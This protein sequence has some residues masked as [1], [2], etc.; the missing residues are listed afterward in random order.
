MPNQKLENLLN[1]SLEVS[2]QERSR[3]QQLETGY[4]PEEKSWELIVKYSGSLDE[5]RKLGV[6]VEEMRNEYA[7]LIVPENLID[8][9]SALPQIEYVEKPKRLFFA[10]NR[11]K[12][13]SCI[14]IL[15]EP[16]RSLTGRGVLIGVLDSG[17]D[18]FHEDFRNPDGTTRIVALWDQTLNQVFTEMDIN[19]ALESGNRGEA[20]MQVPSVDGSG[21]GTSVAGIAAGNGRESDGAYRG[22]AYESRLLIVKLGTARE[23]GFP[24]TTELMRAVDFVVGRAV[25]M[26]M[27]L[28]VNISFGNTYGSHDGTGLLETFLDDIGNYGRN[29]IV[30]GSGNEGA[31]AGH[32][33][34]IFSSGGREQSGSRAGGASGYRDANIELSVAP[35][36][37][38]LSVQLWKAYSDQFTVSLRTPSG[39]VLG[40][41]SEQ[42]G[43]VR[44]RYQNTQILVYYGKPGPFSVSQEIYFDFVP[45]EGS[46]V[47]SGIWT[48]HLQPQRIVQGKYDFWL[49]S[50]AVLNFSTRFLQSTPDTTLTIPSSAA[51]VI[52]VGAYNSATNAYADF[53]GRGF[54]R[55]TDQVKPDLCAPGVG[56]MAPGNGGGY[57]SVTGTSF[58]TPVVAGSA[59]LLMQWGI[60]EGNDPFL[61][62]E[63]VKAYL[64]RGARPLPGF[65]EYPNPQVGYGALCVRDSL[66]V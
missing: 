65:G 26:V 56:L 2:P 47:E 64:R 55:M 61:Y 32:V 19:R 45:D 3:S 28:V 43:P 52:T 4:M 18:Y 38:G 14:N 60:V 16:S 59:A 37:S 22:V 20:R 42:L 23:E 24:R 5:V 53:S 1:L 6:Q 17:I 36:E 58:A 63:K 7:I 13:A 12:S 10:V 9:V 30:V 31:T 62:G 57:R 39:E 35:Y 66:P 54:T 29:T 8:S 41:L 33:S 44:F 34:G 27:P 11:A 21:H 46:Y 51:K 40:P 50:S 15:Q 49:P 48:F 25:E